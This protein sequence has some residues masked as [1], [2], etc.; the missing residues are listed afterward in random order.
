MGYSKGM[1]YVPVE[2]YHGAHDTKYLPFHVAFSIQKLPTPEWDSALISSFVFLLS[3]NFLH[4][5]THLFGG[6]S[7]II[8]YVPGF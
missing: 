7:K 5:Y 8:N 4:S 3:F 1:G 2:D 6:D